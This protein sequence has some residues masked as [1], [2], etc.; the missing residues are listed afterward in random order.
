MFFFMSL[1]LP[2]FFFSFNVGLKQPIFERGART[3]LIQTFEDTRAGVYVVAS[4]D[5]KRLRHIHKF[6]ADMGLTKF[7]EYHEQMDKKLFFK[8]NFAA[9]L[10]A[11]G[12]IDKVMST[13]RNAVGIFACSFSHRKLLES[14]MRS[15]D[16]IAVIFE[17]D[18]IQAPN[19]TVAD[20]QIALS[21]MLQVPKRQWNIQ[22]PGFCFELCVKCDNTCAHCTNL[23]RFRGQSGSVYAP[24]MRPLC[25][26][27][28]IFDRVAAAILLNNFYPIHDGKSIFGI[29]FVRIIFVLN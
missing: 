25:T 20:A 10:V 12:T 2:V 19:T 29:F 23:E 11:N 5:E 22:Y 3:T 8:P 24:A 9:R 17:D 15:N 21:R 6:I 18:V 26:H 13:R 1:L 4:T 7:T 16:D 28:L 27:A 14:F